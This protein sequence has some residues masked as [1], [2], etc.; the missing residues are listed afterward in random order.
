MIEALFA[1]ALITAVHF[2]VVTGFV[3]GRGAA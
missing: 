2:H 3:F 1:V